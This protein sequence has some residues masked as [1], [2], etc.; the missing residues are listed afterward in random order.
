MGKSKLENAW[1]VCMDGATKCAHLCHE[2]AGT[3]ITSKINIKVHT[4]LV[5][6]LQQCDFSSKEIRLTLSQLKDLKD[7]L[8]QVL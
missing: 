3:Q 4:N 5:V 2:I 8:N 6:E 1:E 7:W